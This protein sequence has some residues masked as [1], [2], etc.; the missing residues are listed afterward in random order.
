MK[1]KETSVGDFLAIMQ[2]REKVLGEKNLKADK[3]KGGKQK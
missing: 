2:I 3:L 1:N